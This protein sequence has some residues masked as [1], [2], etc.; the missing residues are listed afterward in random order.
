MSIEREEDGFLYN[1]ELPHELK[2]DELGL[3]LKDLT[4]E[5]RARIRIL[6]NLYEKALD[7]GYIDDKEED[8]LIAESYKISEAI[9]KA[10]N[11]GKGSG[12]ALTVIGGLLLLIGSAIGLRQLSR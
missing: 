12:E 4:T 3:D 2:L 7:D 9:D 6:D 5:L 8:Q 10:F 11:D 1:H